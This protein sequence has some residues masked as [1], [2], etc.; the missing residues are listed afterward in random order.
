M[1]LTQWVGSAERYV[2]EGD[3]YLQLLNQQGK[4][5]TQANRFRLYP[6]RDKAG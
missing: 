6:R 3:V 4:K 5:R 1:S 2:L